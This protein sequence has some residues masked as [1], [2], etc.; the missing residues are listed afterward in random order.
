MKATSQDTRSG[1]SAA[2]GNRFFRWA[3]LALKMLL[4]VPLSFYVLAFCAVIIR[5]VLL[6][7]TGY[8]LFDY[9]LKGRG[10]QCAARPWINIP[11]SLL[12]GTATAGLLWGLWRSR[13]LWQVLAVGCGG[14]GLF[15]LL[16]QVEKFC[17]SAF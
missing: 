2:D 8:E 13:R 9:A 4:A 5:D 7:G 11:M 14:A 1:G 12:A 10:Y 3:L 6:L 15:V 16:I 17:D